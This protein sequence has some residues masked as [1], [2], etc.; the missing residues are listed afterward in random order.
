V[1]GSE[2]AYGGSFRALL[3]HIPAMV[4]VSNRDG[5]ILYANPATQAVSGYVAEEFPALHFFDLI[6][7]EDRPRCEEALRKLIASPGLSLELEH[8]I[9]HKDGSW[10]WVEGTFASLFDDPEVGG[11]LATIRDVTGR[12]RAEEKLRE[13]EERLQRALSIDTVGVL[14]FNLDGRMTGAN[15]AFERM[16]G[17]SWGELNSM[18]WKILTVP[19][20]LE[21]TMQA[22][23]ELATSGEDPQG[24]LAMV[25]SV[26][27]EAALRQRA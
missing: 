25:G 24:R 18:D 15:E 17:Y 7:P 22:A 12:K 9:R 10:R 8:R 5:A 1:S 16:S 11:V 20:F 27:A 26:R 2:G 23:E 14:F 4:T 13:S 3:E 21:A 6:H 19:E